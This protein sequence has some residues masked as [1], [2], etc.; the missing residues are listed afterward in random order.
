[1]SERR[2]WGKAGVRLT[3]AEARA[4]DARHARRR[5]LAAI[6]READDKVAYRKWA[7]G[8]MVPRRISFA[9]DEHELYGPEV[10]IACKAQEPDVDRWEAGELYPT[11]EQVLALAELTGTTPRFFMES[12]WEPEPPAETSLRFHLP[13]SALNDPPSVTRF[14]PEAI[15]AM[16]AT[17]D[18]EGH[19]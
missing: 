19:E 4:N 14:A 15:A 6:H 2:R 1:M 12:G 5:N 8:L 3:D 7:A 17:L 13:P 9:L 16:K 18:G 11:W 10:D